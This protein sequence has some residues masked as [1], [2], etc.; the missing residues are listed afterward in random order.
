MSMEPPP[1]PGYS[2]HQTPT[3]EFYYVNIETGESQ[4][5]RPPPDHSQPPQT[6]MPT[7]SGQALPVMKEPMMGP[8]LKFAKGAILL[9]FVSLFMPYI[10]F[11]GIVEVTGI[12][13][14]S[15]SVEMAEAIMEI[16]PD[17]LAG[18]GGEC[19]YANDGEC[20]EPFLCEEGTDGN[21]CGTSGSGG[22][23]DFDVPFRFYMI[24]IGS[25]MVL[26]SPF[27]IILSGILSSVTVFSGGKLPK[28]LG[29]IHLAFFAFLFLMLAI[30]GTVLDDLIGEAGISL[31]EFM[32]FGLW[33]GGLSG[34]G[35]I[36]EKS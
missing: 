24:L 11:G 9:M 2:I 19:P 10:T 33:M 26:I 15:E 21:D 29:S 14:I 35:L 36:Y 1:V 25:I 32:G 22:D 3:G 23:I 7:P 5:E 6:P 30:G 4:W 20:D 17:E 13:I 31:V 34:I 18:T 27:F 12:D 28:I 16:E 8:D